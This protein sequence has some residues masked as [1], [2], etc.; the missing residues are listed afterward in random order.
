MSYTYLKKK[1][2]GW[3]IIIKTTIINNRYVYAYLE[4]KSF[5]IFL[6]NIENN[7]KKNSL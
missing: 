4:K 1:S 6:K 2:G 3:L 5:F 7:E